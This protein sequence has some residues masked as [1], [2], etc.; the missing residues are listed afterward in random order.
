MSKGMQVYFKSENDASSAK[1][2]LQT[3]KVSNIFMEELDLSRQEELIMPVYPANVA[4]TGSANSTVPIAPLLPVDESDSGEPRTNPTLS[5]LLNF[6]VD[7][8]DYHKT[9]QILG[10]FDC[11][12]ESD[13]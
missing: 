13:Q 10:E 12:R 4:S 5:H 11:Y 7:E 9:L 3:L 6:S 1:A 2:K 8:E